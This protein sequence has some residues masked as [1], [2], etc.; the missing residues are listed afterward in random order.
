[1]FSGNRVPAEAS[2]LR[3]DTLA[4]LCDGP[5]CHATSDFPL[6]ANDALFLATPLSS[7]WLARLVGRVR[8]EELRTP[9][10]PAAERLDRRFVRD[11]ARPRCRVMPLSAA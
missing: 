2:G 11:A 3:V 4:L 10:I 1:M 5:S 8:N 6:V 9:R 7:T